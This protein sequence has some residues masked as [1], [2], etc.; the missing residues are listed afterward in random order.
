MN[1]LITI[2]KEINNDIDY[3]KVDN[4]ID[5]RYLDSLSILSLIAI[6]EEEYDIEIKAIDITPDNFNS[7]QKIY[8]LITRLLDE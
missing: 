3:E 4:L 7:A 6:L 8:E 2:L 1:K 5:G